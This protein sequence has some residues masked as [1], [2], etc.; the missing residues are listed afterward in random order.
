MEHTAIE[1]NISFAY[2]SEDEYFL[3]NYIK[4]VEF[5]RYQVAGQMES[6][7]SRQKDHAFEV[8]LFA[9][10][11]VAVILICNM[12]LAMTETGVALLWAMGAISVVL[13]YIAYIFVMP[14]C[15]FKIIKGTVI[16]CINKQ[17]AIG[18]WAARRFSLPLY[19]TEIQSC[20]A[21]LEKYRILLENLETCQESLAA[22]NPLNRELLE[23][24]INNTDLEPQIKVV[25]PNYGKLHGF[26]VT[27]SVIITIIICLF[28]L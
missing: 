17:N 26:A 6:A 12:A 28:I 4:K 1:A 16:L 21:Y 25:Y 15:L 23:D 14:V 3:D 18:I 27:I 11:L 9:G 20:Q 13:C 22:G 8:K 5:A 24:Q 19:S 2:L 7:I 10:I